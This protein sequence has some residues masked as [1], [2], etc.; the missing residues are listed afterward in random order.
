MISGVI[1]MNHSTNHPAAAFT[2]GSH[3]ASFLD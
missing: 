1:K 3:N 2:D